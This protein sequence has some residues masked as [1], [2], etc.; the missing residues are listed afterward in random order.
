MS[1]QRWNKCYYRYEVSFHIW[2]KD[3]TEEVKSVSCNTDILYNRLHFW[4]KKR[5]IGKYKS[6]M[7][8]KMASDGQMVMC[9][10]LQEDLVL[11]SKFSYM[12][13]E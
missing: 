12:F 1:L 7:V 3:K 5:L 11:I 8:E 2:N 4:N 13:K 6:R 9:E 10:L